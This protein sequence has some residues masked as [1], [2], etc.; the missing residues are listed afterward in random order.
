MQ[1]AETLKR[2]EKITIYYLN[3]SFIAQALYYII[4]YEI[5]DF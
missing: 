3:F 2:F 1:S 5:Y 4:L